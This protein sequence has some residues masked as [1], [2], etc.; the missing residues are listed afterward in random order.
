MPI[1]LLRVYVLCSITEREIIQVG[2][3]HV[4][5]KHLNFVLVIA[6]LVKSALYKRG[7]L[8]VTS[9]CLLVTYRQTD[10]TQLEQCVQQ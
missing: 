10:L 3:R 2:W 6:L 9:S 4:K 8:A 1:L 7:S 5:T